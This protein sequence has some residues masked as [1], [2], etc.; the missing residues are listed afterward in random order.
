MYR[1]H[2]DKG[3]GINFMQI[4]ADFFM[5]GPLGYFKMTTLLAIFSNKNIFF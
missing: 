2:A 3:E 5:D 4:S 1:I